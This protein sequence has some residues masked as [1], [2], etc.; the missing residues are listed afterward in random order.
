MRPSWVCTND[1]DFLNIT[2]V[3]NVFGI[4]MFDGVFRECCLLFPSSLN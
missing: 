2:H 3:K 1:A 4:V